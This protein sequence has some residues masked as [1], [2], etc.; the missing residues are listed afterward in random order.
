MSLKKKDRV[1][2]LN[3]DGVPM[4]EGTIDN[5]N[6]FREPSMKYAVAADFYDEDYLFLGEKNL[7][8]IQE[9]S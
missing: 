5:V 4:G 6:E 3:S 7:V 9:E 1:T 8:K 2:V